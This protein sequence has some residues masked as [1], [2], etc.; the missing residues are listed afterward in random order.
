MDTSDIILLLIVAVISIISSVMKAKKK[1][2]E[3]HSAPGG[4]P[5][6][7]WRKYLLEDEDEEENTPGSP[8]PDY[9]RTTSRYEAVTLPPPPP[10]YTAKPEAKSA[11]LKPNPSAISADEALL[12]GDSE[13]NTSDS[14]LGDFDLRSAVI[15]SEILKPKFEER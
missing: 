9:N 1:P 2:A 15:Y 10:A 5:E 14:G 8:W 11:F 3:G 4:S 7:S 13:A 6:E 12:Q